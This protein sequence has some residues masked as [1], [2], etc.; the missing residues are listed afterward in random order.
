MNPNLLQ[1][2][3]YKFAMAEA[4]AP[5]RRETFYYSH[6]KGGWQYLP[7]D[8][9]RYV[10]ERL[11]QVD[12]DAFDYLDTHNYFMG[13]AFRQ[14]IRQTDQVSV[15]GLPKGSWFCNREPVFSV[16]G[17]SALVS[18][19]EPIIL[20]LNRIIQIAT[21]AKLSP[22]RLPEMTGTA[23][24]DEERYLTLDAF[25]MAGYK[26]TFPI[27]V[28]SDAYYDAV[29]QRAKRLVEIL[30]DPNRAFEVGMR[31]V[32]C[33]DQHR[34]ALQA[35]K[36]AGILRTS[37]VALAC[38]L[39]MI[40][41]GTMGHEH[42]QRHGDD[43]TAY[44]AMRDRFPGF[45][46]YLPD[47]FATLDSGVPAALRV[48]A[49]DPGRNSGVR[50]DSEH[51]IRGHYTH[52]VCRAREA[53]LLP[54]LCLESGWDEAKTIEFEG[55]RRMLDW[56]ADRQCY[57]YGGFLVKPEWSHFGRDDV[58]AVWKISQ[59]GEMSTMKFG[60]E[61]GHG[62]ESIPGRPVV[63]R[64]HIGMASYDGPL[65]YVAQEGEDW[66]PPVAAT[67]LS[68]LADM[69]MSAKFG[70]EV[71]L[72]TNGGKRGIAYSPATQALVNQCYQK[73]AENIVRFAT[74]GN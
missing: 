13:G 26:P 27:R 32:S 68:G 65:G 25:D 59:S 12:A 21:C 72:A 37:N 73:R 10:M 11:P 7:V 31:A 2:D 3:G 55:L 36:A 56:S 60:D 42:V 40:P 58:S 44:K 19:L 5:L 52:T 22:E 47:T 4:G 24:C 41:V 74:E 51:G 63:W 57:G 64:P 18:W 17:P 9:V 28:E 71:L 53:G 14:A 54:V 1:T 34:I 6:R 33:G 20:R 8:V 49:D 69:P 39:D 15:K 45:I 29:Y 30:G 67:L 66:R 35:I 46:F 23:T 70:K 43:H 61:P 62:K 38:G 16:T 50:F 48:M